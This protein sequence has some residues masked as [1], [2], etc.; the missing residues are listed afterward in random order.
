M[1]E[2]GLLQSL[3]LRLIDLEDVYVVWQVKAIP[4]ISPDRIRYLCSIPPMKTMNEVRETKGRKGHSLA[5]RP[6]QS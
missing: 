4:Q 6:T 2:V 1:I 5:G 3:D